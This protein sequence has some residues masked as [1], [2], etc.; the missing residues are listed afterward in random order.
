[1]NLVLTY[2]NPSQ[3]A[4]QD[5]LASLNLPE[6]VSLVSSGIPVTTTG[7][8][9][10]WNLGNLPAGSPVGSIPITLSLS[11]GVPGGQILHLS[12]ILSTSTPEL[13]LL[14]NQVQIQVETGY[15]A[16]LPNLNK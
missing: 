12:Y 10:Q 8:T 5:A 7:S 4:A 1:M 9:L 13:E 2:A 14:N 15:W 6:G 3:V 16:Y 11:L